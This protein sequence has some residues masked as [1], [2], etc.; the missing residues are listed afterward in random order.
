VNERIRATVA[1]RVPDRVPVAPYVANWAA[2]WSGLPLSTYCQDGTAMAR[3]HQAAWERIGYDIVFPDC[4]NYYL[5]EGFGCRTVI[6]DD[7]IASLK[8]P[9]VDGFEAVLDLEVPQPER[10]GRM[11][12]ILEA[13]SLL[14]ASLGP[15]VTIR[16]PGTGPFA[17]ASYLVG[18]QPFLLAMAQ[19]HHGHDE[20]LRPAV[21]HML[22]ITTEGLISFGLAEIEAGADIIQCGDSLASCSVISPDMYEAWVLP[23]HQR[24]FAAW[25]AAGA[26]TA[27]HICGNNTKV[28]G[29]QADTGADIVAIDHL[30]DLAHAKQTIGDRVCLIGNL[31]PVKTMLLGTPDDVAKGAEACLGVAAPGGRYILGT[32][33]EVPVGTP[34]ENLEALVRSA[35]GYPIAAPA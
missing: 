5:A 34:I 18:M 6:P 20:S 16:A 2:R 8:Q 17:L 33:C 10:D 30:V 11:P 22:E 13:I 28:L 15:D 21:E 9:A 14:R 19:V 32:G 25:K 35:H 23:L 7:D 26:V 27:L 29:L 12:V 1:G 3:V 24:V 4:D 31:D